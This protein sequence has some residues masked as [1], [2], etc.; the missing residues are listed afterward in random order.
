MKFILDIFYN[1]AFLAA[2]ESGNL[3]IAQL[4]LTNEKLDINIICILMLIFLIK[5]Q[6]FFLITFKFKYFN[7]ISNK[8]FFN[9]ITIYVF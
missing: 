4:L 6:A 1:T 5:F 7:Q 8:A 3:E 9:Y 2:V